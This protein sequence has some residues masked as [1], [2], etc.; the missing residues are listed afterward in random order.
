[1]LARYTNMVNRKAKNPKET[2]ALMI[3]LGERARR[4][5][6]VTGKAVENRHAMSVISGIVD[7]ETAK[8]TAQY[9]G[10]KSNVE[11]LKRKVMDFVNLVTAHYDD[12]MDIGRMQEQ[13]EYQEEE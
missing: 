4:V 11:T 13:Q 6:E 12:K 1:M 7:P 8:H 2:R 10:L 3:E 9:Q 5:E